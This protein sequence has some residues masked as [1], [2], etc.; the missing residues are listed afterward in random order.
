MTFRTRR[1]WPAIA[2]R[3]R[4]VVCTRTPGGD[5][6]TIVI[7][8]DDSGLILSFHG[9][10]RTTAAPC[11]TEAAELIEALRTAVGAPS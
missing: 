5:A 6:C 3:R 10:M 11:P 1:P 2:E 9:A 7:E 8:R 4:F